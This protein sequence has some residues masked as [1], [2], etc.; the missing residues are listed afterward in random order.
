MAELIATRSV[1]AAA[2]MRKLALAALLLGFGVVVLGAY[3]RLTAAGLGC[4]DWPGCYGHLTPIGA[5]ESVA[6]G[7]V[8][9]GTPLD[10][11]KA[12]R[13]MI[14]RYA[15]ST[16]GLLIVTIAALAIA[17]RHDPIVSPAYALGLLAT[18]VA[19]GVLG[20]LTVTWQLKPLVVTLHL[21]FGLTTLALLWWLWLSLRASAVEPGAVWRAAPPRVA[22]AARMRSPLRGLALLALAALVAQIALGGWTSSHYAA[23][24]C[25]DFPTC[26]GSWWPAMDFRDAFAL[27]TAHRLDYAGGLLPNP[28]RTAI[29]FTHRLGALVATCALVAAAVAALARGTSRGTRLAGG[30]VLLA[31][32]AQLTIGISMVLRG[33]PLWLAT[34]HNAG[35]ALTLLAVVA[36]VHSLRAPA[37]LAAPI[38][39]PVGARR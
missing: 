16:L 20:M 4:P 8:L 38:A 17:T 25:P 22:V 9:P 19:Q 23:V 2:W 18:V 35:A 34:A 15:A 21:L 37:A 39:R 1:P 11:G 12:W 3:V 36:L 7:A 13:E 27:S 10:V 30:A 26:Q 14:H 31:L 32:A 6:E 33:F 29:H 28:A 24:A 5:E